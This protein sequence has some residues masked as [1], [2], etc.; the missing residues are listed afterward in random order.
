MQFI[1]QNFDNRRDNTERR[2]GAPKC[3][4]PHAQARR[5]PCRLLPHHRHA[6]C[7]RVCILCPARTQAVISLS[8]MLI[9]MFSSSD[10][11][12]LGILEY[13]WNMGCGTLNTDSRYNIFPV[14]AE[15]RS[16]FEAGEWVLLPTVQQMDI[17]WASGSMPIGRDFP[18]IPNGIFEYKLLARQCMKGL[19]IRRFPLPERAE[20]AIPL[21]QAYYI[22]EY[23]YCEL[24]VLRS[25]IHPRFV[26]WNLGRKAHA[27]LWD[28]VAGAKDSYPLDWNTRLDFNNILAHSGML[29]T[30]WMEHGRLPRRRPS[31]DAR[32]A[33]SISSTKQTKCRRATPRPRPS[34]GAH[35]ARPSG[36]IPLTSRNLKA[37]RNSYSEPS[38]PANLRIMRWRVACECGS[39]DV[40]DVDEDAIQNGDCDACSSEC[41]VENDLVDGMSE[42]DP[43]E[44][45][46]PTSDAPCS[47]PPSRAGTPPSRHG[48]L[49]SAQTV[50]GPAT[51]PPNLY[52]AVSNVLDL[53]KPFAPPQVP[54]KRASVEVVEVGDSWGLP[55][56]RTK[57]D[58]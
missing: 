53:A 22:H 15:L 45:L 3:T 55:A 46:P 30:R 10:Y 16:R 38:V 24:G 41:D 2:H 56:K 50:P 17:Y 37:L 5:S 52:D 34:P 32:K 20:N 18:D 58:A 14:T 47:V 36:V 19:P 11:T 54:S 28:F 8:S 7:R 26:I 48:S 43:Q 1:D 57:M 33:P 23:P 29:Y 6:R 13:A 9:R 25:H 39:I 49:V 40:D 44:C 27:H 42:G 12:Q 35:P 21:P 51:P 31:D 4:G